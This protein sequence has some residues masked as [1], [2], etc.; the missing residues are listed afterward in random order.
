MVPPGHLDRPCV[1]EVM[2]DCWRAGVVFYFVQPE[3]EGRSLAPT[4]RAPKQRHAACRGKQ[5]IAPAVPSVQ[6]ACVRMQAR[7]WSC[8]LL[9]SP[10]PKQTNFAEHPHSRPSLSGAPCFLAYSCRAVPP[11][12]PPWPLRPKL[13]P[14]ARLHAPHLELLRG[15]PTP[16]YPPKYILLTNPKPPPTHPCV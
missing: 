1:E 14:H 8:L 6:H 3:H 11:P 12:P 16:T 2:A 7:R 15:T 10:P 4:R 9:P 5:L 13:H